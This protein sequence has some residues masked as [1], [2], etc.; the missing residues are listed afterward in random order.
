MACETLQSAAVGVPERAEHAPLRAWP[1][2]FGEVVNVD[3]AAVAQGARWSLY[4]A[5]GR[6]VSHGG[7]TGTMGLHMDTSTLHAGTYLL[8]MRSDAGS[9]SLLIVRE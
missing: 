2:P 8:T 3:G 7:V 5:V 9:S 1:V 4:D 6:E